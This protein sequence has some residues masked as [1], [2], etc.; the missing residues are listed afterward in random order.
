MTGKQIHNPD[1]AG[2]EESNKRPIVDLNKTTMLVSA[3][4][5]QYNQGIKY[6]Q[7]PIGKQLQWADLD[8]I[9]NITQLNQVD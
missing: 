1:T 2:T 4:P 8:F 5:A 9:T 6:H 7:A 3:T